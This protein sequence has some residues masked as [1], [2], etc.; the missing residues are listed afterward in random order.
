VMALFPTVWCAL[1]RWALP[2]AP[3]SDQLTRLITV[4]GLAAAWVLLEWVRS[5]FLTGFPWLPLAASMWQRPLMLQGAAVGGAWFVSF[6]I[7][8]FNLAL[9]SYLQRL[10]L[11]VKERR[12]RFAPE[13]YVAVLVL[14]GGSFG[15]FVNERGGPPREPWFRAGFMQPYIPQTLK[16]DESEAPEI[17]A[18]IAR[19]NAQLAAKDPDLILWPEAVMTKALTWHPALDHEMNRWVVERANEAQIPILFGALAYEVPPG[20][21]PGLTEGTWINGIFLAEPETGLRAQFY[22]KRHRVPFGEYVPLRK[23]LPFIQKFVPIGGD[24]VAGTEPSPLLVNTPA[25]AMVVGPLICYEDVFPNLARSSVAAGADLLFV[26]TNNAWYGETGAAEQHAAHAVLRAVETRRNV[27]RD[28]NGGWSGWID[29]LGY[30]RH[31]V[32]NK[33]GS[34]YVRGSD[35]V[36]VTRNPNWIGR[37]SYFVQHGD[38]FIIVSAALVGVMVLLLRSSR[39]RFDPAPATSVRVRPMS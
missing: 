23:V 13:F 34:V 31:V 32:K 29:E 14:F 2:R 21:N 37:E 30:I 8:C 12:G 9:G 6:A 19:V 28:G 25:G 4:L 27:L 36:D 33:E 3:W 26:A 38:W 1:V 10:W 24:I 5:W 17:L 7:V 35:T 20:A 16:W 39:F 15:V 11:W 22:R 18:T